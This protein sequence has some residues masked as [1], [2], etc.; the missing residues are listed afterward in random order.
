MILGPMKWYVLAESI[1][2]AIHTDLTVKPDRSGV[3]PGSLIADDECDCGLLAIAYAQIYPSEV[4]PDLI[5]NPSGN[6]DASVEIG[7][8]IIRLMRCAP[9][10][11]T[12][13]GG[14]DLA[15][16][17]AA[18]DAS[19]QE[20]M[21]DAYEL[22]TSTRETLCQMEEARDISAYLLRPLV[23]QGPSGGCVGNE[24]RVLV[25]LLRG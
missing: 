11:G 18:L 3:V 22:I 9:N 5:N 6:C 2:Q 4:F 15:P 16:S 21:R 10:P 19:A 7:E 24:L 14:N 17:V 20:I 23:P 8:L 13:L 25:G 1:R 12:D